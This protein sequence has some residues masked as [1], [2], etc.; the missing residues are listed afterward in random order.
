MG[1]LF[2]TDGVRGI[3]NTELTPELA[4]RLGR[5]SVPVL[6]GGEKRPRIL[7]GRDTRIS[8]DMLEAAI[9][10]GFCAAGADVLLAGIMPTPAVAYLTRE[11]SAQA[12]VVLSASHNPA[13]YNGIKFFFGDGYKLPDAVEDEIERGLDNEPA[14]RPAGG[15][16]G[17]VLRL[18]NAAD[19]Y[20]DYAVS[21]ADV[22]LSGL[23]VVVDCA[24]GAAARIAPA[25]LKRLGA[26]V[27]AVNAAPDGLN[28]NAGCGSTHP[29]AMQAAVRESGADV[30]IAHDGDADRVL[31]ADSRG[32]LVD[33]DQIMTICALDRLRRG[34]LPGNTLVATVMSNLGLDLALQPAGAKVLRTKVGDRY[35]LEE[36]LARGLRMGGEQSGHIIFLDLNTT[37]DGIITALQLLKVVR[38]SGEPLHVLAGQMKRLPQVLLNVPVSRREALPGNPRIT[39]AVRQAEERL[40]EFGR[41][42][43]RASGTEPLV[44]VMVEGEDEKALQEIASQIAGIIQQ[45]L[46]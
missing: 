14:G 42:L 8:G 11:L 5:A 6:A 38:E 22:D 20:I 3:A 32:E 44:R 41:L 21:T 43:V 45:E 34:E 35:V 31:A 7:I 28:I 40:G 13:E 4:F 15:A 23:K 27:R 46:A 37:G 26:S 18:E 10:A 25:V 9:A 1:N 12:G 24:N 29:E 16:V 30:G 2:G 39:A 36:M 19:K 17:R 33:G